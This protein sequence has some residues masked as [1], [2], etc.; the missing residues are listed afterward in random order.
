M[1]VKPSEFRDDAAKVGFAVMLLRHD[2]ALWIRTTYTASDLSSLSWV[3]FV[4]A[5]EGHFRPVDHTRRARD[6]LAECV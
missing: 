5:V 3:D 2:A 1:A 6:V 4:A